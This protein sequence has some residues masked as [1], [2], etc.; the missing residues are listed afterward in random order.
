M[1]SPR[2]WYVDIIK[3]IIWGV[4]V[5]FF[6]LSICLSQRLYRELYEKEKDKVHST[7]DTPEIRQVKM[8]QKAVSDVRDLLSSCHYHS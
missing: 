2:P 3:M 1:Y 8:T 4:V 5:M 6:P 7:Y